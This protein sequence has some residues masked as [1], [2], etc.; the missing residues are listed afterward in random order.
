MKPHTFF[1]VRIFIK[2]LGRVNCD[3][4]KINTDILEFVYNLFFF[5]LC[6][7][8]KKTD[9]FKNMVLDTI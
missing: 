9:I 6:N 1:S 7:K 4:V 5:L 2:I 3:M 8:Q